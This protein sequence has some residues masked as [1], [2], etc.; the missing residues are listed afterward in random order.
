MSRPA[1][2]SPSPLLAFVSG[3]VDTAVFVLMGGLFVAHVTGNFVLIGATLTGSPVSGHGG[4]TRLQLIAFPVFFVA[5]MLAAA[6]APGIAQAA[7]TRMLLWLVTTIVIAS[8]VAGVLADKADAALALALVAAMG[9]LNAAQ[10]LDPG[11]GPPFTVMT[12]NVTGLAIAAARGLR[13][14]PRNGEQATAVAIHP[15]GVLVAMF[16]LGC[17]LGALVQAFA[18][19]GAMLLPG[20]LLAIWLLVR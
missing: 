8:G 18:G 14:T 2:P 15:M 13:L 4:S 1:S 16:A 5:A 7:R 12:G 9:L 19:F 11:M 17:A 10:R 6:I 3:Y 20:A